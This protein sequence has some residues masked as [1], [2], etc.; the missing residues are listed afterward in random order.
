MLIFFLL[1]GVLD[2]TGVGGSVLTMAAAVSRILPIWT[3]SRLGVNWRGEVDC[4]GD[5]P[6]PAPDPPD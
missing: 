3:S 5:S 6:A 1:V 2:S 4:G